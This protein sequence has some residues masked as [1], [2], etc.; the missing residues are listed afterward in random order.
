M[1]VVALIFESETMTDKLSPGVYNATIQGFEP[2]LRGA[3]KANLR[4]KLAFA[5]L[6]MTGTLMYEVRLHND[7][8][9][10]IT[11]PWIYK[12]PRSKRSRH[13]K[14]KPQ[15]NCGPRGNNPW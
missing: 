15:P 3:P 14:A 4:M 1:G 13:H 2:S 6:L 8:L 10:M 7:N 9:S 12:S 11:H 5:N